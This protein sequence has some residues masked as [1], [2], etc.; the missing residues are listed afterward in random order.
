MVDTEM[1]RLQDGDPCEDIAV[2]PYDARLEA[3]MGRHVQSIQRL[4]GK[5]LDGE[6]NRLRLLRFK[7]A[8]QRLVGRLLG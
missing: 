7:A 5:A 8:K 1:S 3:S 6:R 4:K 2:Q